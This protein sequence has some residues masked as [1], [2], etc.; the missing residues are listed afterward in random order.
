[1]GPPGAPPVI[2]SSRGSE[3]SPG[4]A[5]RLLHSRRTVERAPLPALHDPA[6]GGAR[7]CSPDGQQAATVT[8][9]PEPPS[10]ALLPSFLLPFGPPTPS[11]STCQ[12]LLQ[13]AS[14][15][16]PNSTS[17]NPLPFLHLQ[18]PPGKANRRHHHQQRRGISILLNC[19]PTPAPLCLLGQEGR[20]V[21]FRQHSPQPT[22]PGGWA[23]GAF[24][25][26]VPS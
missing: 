8:E 16:A 12:L 11:S 6:G 2:S 10:S 22:A 17:S 20:E 19:P 5:G 3:Y 24:G 21:V 23:E 1:M 7:G 25:T 13:S 18:R 26:W 9:F 4:R 14:P 15:S